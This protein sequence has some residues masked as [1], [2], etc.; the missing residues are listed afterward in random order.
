LLHPGGVIALADSIPSMDTIVTAGADRRMLCLDTRM[1]LAVVHEWKD[2]KD[3]I[4]SLKTFGKLVFSGGGNGWVLAH[5]A[6]SGQCLYGLG[7]NKAAVRCIAPTPER[8][9][10]A[11][12]D[13]TA[14]VYDF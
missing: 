1:D 9:V 3:F 2:H 11:G 5:D 14:V 7:A 10:C 12:D 13:G 8:L 4:Y 6:T